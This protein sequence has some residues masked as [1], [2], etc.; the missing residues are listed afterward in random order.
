LN[1]VVEFPA[2]LGAERVGKILGPTALPAPW[3]IEEDCGADAVVVV[4]ADIQTTVKIS[5]MVKIK[6]F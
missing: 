3:G 1:D 4:G 6:K 2:S 5:K